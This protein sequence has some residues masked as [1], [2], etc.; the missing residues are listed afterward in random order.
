MIILE[1]SIFPEVSPQSFVAAFADLI[2]IILGQLIEQG[3][4]ELNGTK[5]FCVMDRVHILKTTERHAQ[6]QLFHIPGCIAASRENAC[7]LFRRK[8]F[9]FTIFIES[10]KVSRDVRQFRAAGFV[11]VLQHGEQEN[12]LIGIIGHAEDC[13]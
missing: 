13:Y 11:H 6:D 10:G 4:V 9:G 5:L 12:G 3:F 2:K 8:A 7:F 1:S